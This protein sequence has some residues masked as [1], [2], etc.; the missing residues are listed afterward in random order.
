MISELLVALAA[1][2]AT[3]VPAEHSPE[4][5]N[6]QATNQAVRAAFKAADVEQIALYHH[7][8]VA[9]SLGPDAFFEGK[10]AL[11]RDLANTFSSVDLEFGEGDAE[12]IESM[13]I[14]GDMATSITR[15]SI[16][17]KPKDGSPGGTARGRAMIVLVKS[18][19]APFGWVTLREIIQPL[20]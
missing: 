19:K 13:V 18:E 4:F 7:D 2:T 17:W 1:Q 16:D 5:A 11:K 8:D 6:I 12:V 10:D 14:C 20:P 9:K 3:C 15:F